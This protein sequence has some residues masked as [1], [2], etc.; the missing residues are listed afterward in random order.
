MARP[1]VMTKDVL[2]KLDE[3]FALGC[4]DTEAC[5]Y[6][7]IAPSTLYL[8]QQDNESFSERK[9][10]LKETPVLAARK[11]VVKSLETDVNSAWKYLERKDGT[12]N[13]KSEIDITSKGEQ[14]Q[15][16]GDISLL[17]AKAAELLK[18]EIT[19]D[20]DTGTT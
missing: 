14:L 1:T 20:P 6:A 11:T 3:A 2:R 10:Q 15:S 7:D 9:A 18:Q 4:S 5:I 8:Y 19:N 17:A 16:T 12:L 13:P